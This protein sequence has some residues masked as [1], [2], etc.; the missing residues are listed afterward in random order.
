[1]ADL[2]NRKEK[3]KLKKGKKECKKESLTAK[4]MR[5]KTRQHTN[6][7]NS[8]LKLWDTRIWTR[9]SKLAC[10]MIIKKTK[11]DGLKH[12]ILYSPITC[13]MR[14]I[15]TIASKKEEKDRKL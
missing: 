8:D 2:Q 9:L 14:T 12:R 6:V 15:S 5:K 1:M 10:W 11:N 4:I 7:H 3:V 13:F